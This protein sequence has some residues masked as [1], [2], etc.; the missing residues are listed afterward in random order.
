MAKISLGDEFTV[1]VQ[2]FGPENCPDHDHSTLI[3]V[4]GQDVDTV[5]IVLN[6]DDQVE[7][8]IWA[9]QNSLEEGGCN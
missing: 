9:L 6:N 5:S 8:L 1:T 3:E 2:H 4:N 7:A